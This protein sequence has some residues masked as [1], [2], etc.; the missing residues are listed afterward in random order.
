MYTYDSLQLVLS[1]R[2]IY[3]HRMQC[4]TCVSHLTIQY[5]GFRASH[6]QNYNY[7]HPESVEGSNSRVFLF[8]T[9][10]ADSDS[11]KQSRNNQHGTDQGFIQG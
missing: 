2:R 11:R 7:R 8:Q 5:A 4:D 6:G 1:Y 9:C 10:F 3:I